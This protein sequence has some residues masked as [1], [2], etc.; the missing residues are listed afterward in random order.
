[1]SKFVLEFE[2]PLVDL[3]ERLE[4]MKRLPEA[5]VSDIASEINVLED[6]IDRLR[7][8]IY[9]NLTPW[10]RV[11]IA[12]HPQRPTTLDYINMFVDDFTELHGD[13]SY[14]DDRAIIAGLGKIAQ[15]RVA[16]VGQQKGKNT[17]DRI[18][19]NFGQPHPEGFRKSLRV[20]RM[21]EKYNLPLICFVDTQGAYPG[22]ESEE[23]GISNAIAENL[24]AFSA[25]KT[26]IIVCNIGEGGSGGAL[27]IGVGDR[28]FMLENAYF[29]VITPE[30]CASILF[31]DPSRAEE[32]ANLLKITAN[33]LQQLG[34]LDGIVP[35]PLGGA[36]RDPE[37]VAWIL[38]R[39]IEQ[40][41]SELTQLDAGRLV[42]SRYA[43]IRS[44]GVFVDEQGILVGKPIDQDIKV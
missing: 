6:Q 39:L 23:R 13:R 24:M 27:G 42:E 16:I 9:A 2:R 22:R 25:L 12:R 17:S 31:S 29:S 4:S 7:K 30:G 44:A 5:H 19:R 34:F 3:E 8:S 40:A 10:Q 14:R 1:M 35:E 36:H 41:L 11:Q 43:R 32:A 18:A 33:H 28:L 15:H 21:A 37:S 26:P 20:A 38:L